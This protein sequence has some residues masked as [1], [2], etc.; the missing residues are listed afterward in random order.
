VYF[1]E[2]H[3]FPFEVAIKEG[4]AL[5]V[6]ASYNDADGIPN[7]ANKTLLTDY[8]IG[9][10]N[11]NGYVI[12]DLGA[13]MRLVEIHFTAENQK[14]AAQQC[15][16]AGIDIDL[17]MKNA[18]FKKIEELVKEGK[19]SQK[20]LD[21][22]VSRIL[23]LKFLL[24]LFE[25]PFIDEQKVLNRTNTIE[26]KALALEAAEKSA[27]LLKNEN[28][29]PLDESRIENLAVIGPMAKNVHLG[30]YSYKPF[31]GISILAGIQN[32]GQGKF[33]VSFAE[34][35][36]ININTGGIK[37]D[38][39][40]KPNSRENDLLLISEAVKTAETADV[41]V[42]VIGENESFAREALGDG[43]LG[44]RESLELPGM[45]NDLA[46]ALLKTGKPII[47]IIMGG[48]PLS[49][50]MVAEKVPAI[51][52]AWYLGQETGTA[53]AKLLFG[54]TNP[55]GKLCISI[56]RSAGQLPVYYSQFPSQKTNY[57]LAKTSPLYQFGHGL[58]YTKFEYSTPELSKSVIHNNEKTILKVTIKNA[59][60]RSGTEV[61][62][63]YIRDEVSSVVRPVIQ[64]KDFKRIQLQAGATETV[65]FI[66][67][68]TKLS[69]INE[70]LERTIEPGYFSIKIGGNSTDLKSVRLFVE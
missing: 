38:S 34:G 18:S 68:K 46:E 19:I 43:L 54:K 4:N 63:L 22:A 40:P 29:L 33:K 32:Y 66:I 39:N 65:E 60:T 27:V 37:G 49:F 5:C 7:H 69:F 9:K 13:V 70:N 17:V 30:G 64:L 10:Y 51:F 44:D 41:V 52:Q 12:S 3:L 31:E 48:R 2:N 42:L 50:N 45:Q 59:G 35:C 14:D 28:I 56:P 55:S 25:N 26:D 20:R 21:E 24:G 57:L 53:I 23:R 15:F 11:F 47:A 58:S 6:M 62:Q 1:H 8:L 16:N 67:D 36:K 61:V